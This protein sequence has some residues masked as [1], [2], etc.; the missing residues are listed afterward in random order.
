MFSVWL[1]CKEQD[2]NTLTTENKNHLLPWR[3]IKNTW[4]CT[5]INPLYML[6]GFKNFRVGK[7]AQKQGAHEHLSV[8]TV[9]NTFRLLNQEKGK[10]SAWNRSFIFLVSVSP[11]MSMK[12]A[13]KLPCGNQVRA[14]MSCTWAGHRALWVKGLP[15]LRT[16]EVPTPVRH[17][18]RCPETHLWS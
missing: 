12:K 8:D 13:P 6:L 5:C 10:V 4:L 14:R 9:T 11:H 16:P 3:L 17:K 1:S 15:S 7:E 18:V 2:L